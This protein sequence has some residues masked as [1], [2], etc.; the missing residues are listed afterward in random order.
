MKF[1]LRQPVEGKVQI[2]LAFPLK[3]PFKKC[4]PPSLVLFG[5][6]LLSLKRTIVVYEVEV[7]CF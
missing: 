4:R 6:I 3:Y 2:V 1:S 5:V 7:V